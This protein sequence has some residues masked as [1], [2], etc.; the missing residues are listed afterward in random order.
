MVITL[1]SDPEGKVGSKNSFMV[2]ATA[3][4]IATNTAI[5]FAILFIKTSSAVYSNSWYT[6]SAKSSHSAEVRILMDTAADVKV[7]CIK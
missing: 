1:S 5:Y 3:T 4:I 7:I 6:S 2:Q